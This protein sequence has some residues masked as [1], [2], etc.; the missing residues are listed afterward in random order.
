MDRRVELGNLGNPTEVQKTSFLKGFGLRGSARFFVPVI[1]VALTLAFPA[2][3]SVKADGG[4]F[5]LDPTRVVRTYTQCG[6]EGYQDINTVFVQQVR[7]PDGF[8]T[9]DLGV[10]A[11]SCENRWTQPDSEIQ[12]LESVQYQRA[13]VQPVSVGTV[14]GRTFNYSRTYPQCGGSIDAM[15][16]NS[17]YTVIVEEFI[18]KGTGDAQYSH[19]TVGRQP[20]QCGNP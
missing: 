1:A 10:I 6:G 7:N 5:T 2:S 14:D 17:A 4:G 19:R 12:T 3:T 18:E 20:G 8:N 11:G 13:H 16:I 9:A 15:D